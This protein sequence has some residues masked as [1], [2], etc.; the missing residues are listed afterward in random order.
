MFPQLALI[1]LGL[2]LLLVGGTGLIRGASAVATRTGVP[3][4][5]IGLT[6]V[7]FGTSTPEL[8]VTVLGALE[9]QPQIAYGNV[10]GSNI[11]NLG[12]VL[13]CAALVTP[14]LIQGQVIRREVPLLL[15]G[16]SVLVVMSLDNVLRG[17]SAML[18]RADGLILILLF[19]IFIYVTVGDVRRRR[20]DPLVTSAELLPVSLK[21]NGWLR[22]LAFVLAGILALGLGGEVTL[23]AGAALADVLGVE[24]ALIGLFVIAIGTSLPEL[25]TSI[26]AAFR[27]EPDLCVGNVVGSNLVNGLFILPV[28]AV[29]HPIPIPDHGLSD[30]VVSLAFT[31]FLVPVFFIGN[32]RLGRPIG[33][34]LLISYGAYLILRTGL[35]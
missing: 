14:M 6:V 10:V 24:P 12:L 31:A 23:S 17:A 20:E 7:A 29:L 9:G 34:L 21:A 19:G 8:M 32:S 1:A 25:V 22:D 30:L 2:G 35:S 33:A 4:L 28:G 3:P 16:T 26:V 15:L 11:A 27:K 13:G 5:I 18:D